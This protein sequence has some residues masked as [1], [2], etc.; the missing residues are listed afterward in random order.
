MSKNA[1]AI[2]ASAS[3]ETGPSGSDLL[4]KAISVTLSQP[5]TPPTGC[6]RC[7]QEIY[8]SFFFDGF[9]HSLDDGE[10]Q[11]N[12]GRLYLAH[13]ETKNDTGI[14]RIYYEGMGRKL[15]T[16]RVGLAAALAKNT[17][18]E[19]KK[20]AG[21]KLEE[22]G[23]NAAKTAA[24]KIFDEARGSGV[25]SAAKSSILHVTESL[26]EAYRP[27]TLAK[28][29]ASTLKDPIFIIS[30]AI[31]TVTNVFPAIRDSEIAAAYL[32]TG[33]DSRVEA[34]LN[35]F[36]EIITELDGARPLKT[37]RVA[38]FGYDR[39]AVIARKFTNEL[40]KKKC[41]KIGE[42]VIYQDDDQ[43]VEVIFD[44]MGLFDSVSS[45]YGDAFFAKILEPAL[46]FVPGDG[47]AVRAGTKGLRMAIA[48]AKKSL[49]QFDTPGEFRKVV[50]HVASTE[51]RFYKLLDSPRNSNE[52]GNLTEI[53]YPG[54]QSDVGG[55]FV[56]GED[57]KSAELARVSARNMLD[58]AWAYGVPVRRPE[59][60]KAADDLDTLKHF[61]FNKQCVV[62]GKSL[63]VNDL[64]RAYTALL[65]TG[66]GTLE[67]HLLAHQKLFI[68]WA[69]TIHD[70]THAASSGNNLFVNEVDTDVYNAIFS[71]APTSGFE[72][73][74]DYYKDVSAG[75][76]P[77]NLNGDR[78]SVDN[79]TDPTIRELATAWVK[80]IALSPEV[81]AFFDNFVHNSI[82]PL[83][84]MSFGDGVFLTLREI[85]DKSH[86]DQLTDK[87]TDAVKSV[88]PDVDRIRRDSLKK[89]QDAGTWSQGSQRY[90]DPLALGPSDSDL[91]GLTNIE[92]D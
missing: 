72:A 71:D 28:S 43:D 35:D 26:K 78:R 55:G 82:T 58:Q 16:E 42:K 76:I 64:F 65:P 73:R 48:L 44:F 32:G 27:G 61:A 7:D 24:N 80:P 92:Q 19:T 59:E 14:Y 12:I 17:Y 4:K 5:S 86:K 36:A 68:S 66:Q 29:V 10:K 22:A 47:W 33:F 51:L 54:S 85:E 3:S 84:N 15:A 25:V 37:I 88:P 75:T 9:G 91:F 6:Y 8:I 63:T 50:H 69:R 53:V 18:G 89:R 67:H 70:R 34:A 49:G 83:N 1:T 23:K 39:G 60:M 87:G 11:S 62:G 13:K 38:V 40:I 57:G 21:N 2:S 77:A 56:E 74:A 90:P 81:I 52:T 41:K 46:N 30:T 79:I 31:S 20:L 45:A